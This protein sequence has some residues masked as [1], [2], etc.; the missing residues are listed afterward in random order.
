MASQSAKN[1]L[2][3]ICETGKLSGGAPGPVGSSP[4]GKI[5]V[6]GR[7]M[8]KRILSCLMALVLCLTLLPTAALAGE[9]EGT[10]Q[11]THLG[12][13]PRQ[14]PPYGGCAPKHAC[15][16]RPAHTLH[17]QGVCSIRRAAKP[18]TAALPY[19]RG[20]FSTLS[21]DSF[22]TLNGVVPILGQLH[23]YSGKIDICDRF[24]MQKHRRMKNV[25]FP[26][27][28]GATGNDARKL[29]APALRIFMA[30]CSCVKFFA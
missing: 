8:K 5:S 12:L 25:R 7:S 2:Y 27:P 29:H 15:G 11:D 23:V 10:A 14:E 21:T 13:S 4:Y 16:R 3:C 17:P 30:R 9:T 26:R 22:I 28:C 6:C 1:M 18:L 19:R 24:A 20:E